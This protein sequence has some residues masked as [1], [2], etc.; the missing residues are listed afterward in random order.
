MGDEIRNA[1]NMAQSTLGSDLQLQFFDTQGSSEGAQAAAAQAAGF[2]AGIVLGP[3]LGAN[4]SAARAGLG[5]N[6]PSILSFSNDIT[7]AG[8]N[9]YIFGLTP[10]NS[11]KRILEFAVSQGK[12][13]IAILFPENDF[14]RAATSAA[15]NMAPLMGIT[16]IASEGYS[17]SAGRD[18][19]ASRQ[20][21]ASRVGALRASVDGLFIP[22]GGTAA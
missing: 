9:N 10:T 14:G 6:S 1:I 11:A 18:G 21:A 15:Q 13:R 2:D 17:P 5:S 22:D 16:I 12:T 3:L 7:K 20:E 8:G 4:I 19:A